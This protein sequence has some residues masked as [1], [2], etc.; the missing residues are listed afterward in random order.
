[1]DDEAADLHNDFF[2]ALMEDDFRRLRAFEEGAHPLLV[3]CHCHPRTIDSLRKRRKQVSLDDDANERHSEL[4]D[5]EVD[6]S[7]SSSTRSSRRAVPN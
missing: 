4:I 5:G 6:P 1:M 7:S 2:V 3:S